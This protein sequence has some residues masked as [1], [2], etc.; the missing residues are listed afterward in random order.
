MRKIEGKCCIKR[1]GICNVHGKWLFRQ[2]NIVKWDPSNSHDVSIKGYTGKQYLDCYK[3]DGT[4]LWRIDMGVNIRAGAHYTQFI[5]YDFNGDGKAEMA[6]K[7][8]PGTKAIIYNSDGSVKNEYYITMPQS[9]ID[10]GYSHD[11]NYVCSADDYREHL[12][13]VFMNWHKHLEVINGNWYSTLERCFGIEDKYTYPLNKEDASEL[14]DYFIHVYAPSKSPK[15]ELDKF[16]GFIYKGPEYLTMFAG[17]G[18]E[19]ETI[20]FKIGRV[21]DGLMWGGLCI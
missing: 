17:D 7:T 15:N 21:D 5:A 20:P 10:A 3:L 13:E 8:A 16:E 2:R 11:D 19:I 6:V 4:L 1:N 14:V 18:T 12:T 9:D